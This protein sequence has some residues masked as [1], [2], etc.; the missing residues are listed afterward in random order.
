MTSQR[1]PEL[2]DLTVIEPTFEGPGS[3]TM[4]QHLPVPPEDPAGTDSVHGPAPRCQQKLATPS[5]PPQPPAPTLP[6]RRVR[7]LGIP[8]DLLAAKT[9][10]IFT[11]CRWQVRAGRVAQNCR[12][13]AFWPIRRE[14]WIGHWHRAGRGDGLVLPWFRGPVVD[15]VLVGPPDGVGVGEVTRR[16]PRVTVELQNAQSR[17]RPTKPLPPRPHWRAAASQ[18]AVRPGPTPTQPRPGLTSRVPHRSACGV[19]AAD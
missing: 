6:L 14:L 3:Q 18:T 15:L 19:R 11:E 2:P 1:P 4:V 10:R 16:P 13:C 5:P 9:D 7:A 17:W 8:P 12:F